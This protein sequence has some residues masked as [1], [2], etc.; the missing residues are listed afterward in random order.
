MVVIQVRKL[1]N[2]TDIRYYYI[3]KNTNVYNSSHSDPTLYATP[4]YSN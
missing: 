2:Q 3:T 1:V 4:Y